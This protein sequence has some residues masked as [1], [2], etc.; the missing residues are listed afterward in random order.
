MN[1]TAGVVLQSVVIPPPVSQN[2]A[3]RQARSVPKVPILNLAGVKAI[4]Q[5]AGIALNVLGVIRIGQHCAT[6]QE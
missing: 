1:K 3:D 2:G 5:I 6:T 4:S